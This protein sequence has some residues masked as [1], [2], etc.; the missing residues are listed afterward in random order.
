MEQHSVVVTGM[1]LISGSANTPEQLWHHIFHQK[2]SI[3]MASVL[4]PFGL[5]DFA[6]SHVE[7]AACSAAIDSI[8]QPAWLSYDKA[9]QMALYAAHQAVHHAALNSEQLSRAGLWLGCNK[10][11]M[12]AHEYA[13]LT[14]HID[15]DTLHIDIDAL[16][17]SVDFEGRYQA[18]RQDNPARLVAQQFAL[19]GP[20]STHCD[21][22]A[23]GGIAIARAMEAIRNGIVDVAVVG[24]TEAMVDYFP[25][26][27]FASV[28]ALASESPFEAT[29]ISRPFDKQRHGFVMGE[30][31]ACLILESAQ[32]AKRRNAH[33]LAEVAGAHVCSEAHK[34]TA[35]TP[36]GSAYAA[37]MQHALQDAAI[38][39][40]Q[41]DHINAH[42]TSTVAN[43][44]CE[45]AAILDL[46]GEQCAQLPITANKSA[47]GHSLA[48]SGLLEAILSV[49]S[50][51]KQTLLPTL[52]FKEGDAVTRQLDIVTTPR[53]AVL[54][55]IL[56][57][58][59]GFGGE[60]C[61][62]I[63]KRS[64]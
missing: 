38:S 60:N 35:S 18:T 54:T 61:S 57:N 56:S 64:L 47:I 10:L 32:H 49:M 11:T 25:M 5:A 28:G 15:P 4:A 33:I 37:C 9:S 39:T 53:T 31:G 36:S 7:P 27:A 44:K 59:F 8:H 40:E 58:S 12:A 1:G 14:R 23:A 21:A 50:L 45:A 29:A 63:L 48:C 19:Q 2:S 24:A 30:G 13:A 62:L 51:Q 55:H 3:A 22:C 42:G 46:F 41:I 26:L 16:A 43:D 6:V 52:N 34:I 17:N 20:I